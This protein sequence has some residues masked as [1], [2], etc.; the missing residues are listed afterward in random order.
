MNAQ[1]QQVAIRQPTAFEMQLQEYTPQ[2]A[3]ALPS[4]IPLDR[5]KRVVIT[6]VNQSPD[7]AKADRRS[8]FNSC[9]KA[10]NDGLLPDG[11]EAALVIFGGKVQY[12]PMIQGVLKRAR[13]TGELAAA[14][15]QVVYERDQFSYSLGDDEHILHNPYIGADRGKPVGAYA[16]AKL[17]DGTVQREFMSVAEIEKTR[18]VSRA[19]SNGPWVS[20]WSE[21]ARKTVAR[22]LFKWLPTSSD[23]SSLFDADES[24]RDEPTVGAIPPRPTRAEFATPLRTAEI[25]QPAQAEEEA[26][27]AETGEII[28]PG[29]PFIV[30]GATNV[31]MSD[32]ED[33]AEYVTALRK[34][35]SGTMDPNALEA[36]L[37]ANSPQF[38]RLP[39]DMADAIRDDF[40]VFADNLTK[41]KAGKARKPDNAP[42]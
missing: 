8:L 29:Q 7:L 20:W 6:A 10:A 27:D 4:H 36:I 39:K 22:R 23:L 9:V 24:M 21:M 17:K 25:D 12:M 26:H 35:A 16:I 42:V 30:I 41:A 13:N 18:A 38:S 5:F 3:A 11:R 31:E 1:A 33:P 14:S 37:D 2:I 34:M 40:A 32:H 28:E 19:K 15:A